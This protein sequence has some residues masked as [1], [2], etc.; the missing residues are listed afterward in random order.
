LLFLFTLTPHSP[1]SLLHKTKKP[2]SRTNSSFI[3]STTPTTSAPP[4]LAR[5][6]SAFSFA[7]SL[8]APPSPLLSPLSSH[9]QSS[10]SRSLLSY[11][12]SFTLEGAVCCCKRSKEREGQ[13]LVLKFQVVE[14][15]EV[16]FL[17]SRD[18]NKS[19]DV[20]SNVGSVLVVLQ[21]F[22]TNH[23]R[24]FHSEQVWLFRFQSK[25]EKRREKRKEKGEK[26]EEKVRLCFGE[27]RA[28]R[29][30]SERSERR[31]KREEV[32]TF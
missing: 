30:R 29:K 19:V 31:K 22:Q 21:Q 2:T 11:H 3:P 24:F 7:S 14:K 25:E 16:V 10:A 6:A 27:W 20:L 9:L 13:Q 32:P 28:E 23:N 8:L 17:E 4:N 12:H 1:F 26:G 15:R 5:K 18:F